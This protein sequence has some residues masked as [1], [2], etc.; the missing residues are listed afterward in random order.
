MHNHNL[1]IAEVFETIYDNDGSVLGYRGPNIQVGETG[2]TIGLDLTIDDQPRMFFDMPD[3]D[4]SSAEL[5]QVVPV[6]Q[7][8]L[9][10]MEQYEGGLND[11]VQARK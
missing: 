1:F 11:G 7:Q 2:S 8:V 10:D 4:F 9:R 3:G 5:R 6:L